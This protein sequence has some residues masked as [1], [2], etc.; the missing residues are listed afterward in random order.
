MIKRYKYTG[1]NTGTNLIN[2]TIYTFVKVNPDIL[3]A[4]PTDN[5]GFVEITR[6][7][8]KIHKDEYGTLERV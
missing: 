8:F 3:R 6:E 7:E 2:G 5:E 4:Y 1:D